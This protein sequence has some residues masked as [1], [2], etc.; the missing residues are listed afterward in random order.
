M[1]DDS[2]HDAHRPHRLERA[3]LA[4]PGTR[5][6]QHRD[7]KRD[8]AAG[9]DDRRPGLVELAMARL[10]RLRLDDKLSIHLGGSGISA[11]LRHWVNEGLMTFFFLVVD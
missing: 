7:R 10:L 11:D 4:T 8:R 5:L 2:S 9:R 3:T 6:P 1:A